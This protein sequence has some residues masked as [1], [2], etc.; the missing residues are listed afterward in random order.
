MS[1]SRT[2]A[3]LGLAARARRQRDAHQL[4][5]RVAVEGDVVDATVR[6]LG[7]HDYAEIAVRNSIRAGRHPPALA[8]EN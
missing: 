6:D 2:Q 3:D 7:G 4:H 1:E 5:R 8:G